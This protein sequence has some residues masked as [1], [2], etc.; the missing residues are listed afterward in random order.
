[1][2]IILP[3]AGLG[4]CLRPLPWSRPKPLVSVGGKPILA[5]VI[6]RV[7]PANPDKI[8]KMVVAADAEKAA[9]AP[10][11]ASADA[12]PAAEQPAAEAGKAAAQ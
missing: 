7:M 1:M 11:P 2:A 8:V 6:D 3:V 10:A 5:H 12:A 4:T 9:A